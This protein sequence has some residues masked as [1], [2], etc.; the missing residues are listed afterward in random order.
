M[1]LELVEHRQNEPTMFLPRHCCC[2]FNQGFPLLRQKPLTVKNNVWGILRLTVLLHNEIQYHA[3]LRTYRLDDNRLSELFLAALL[4]ADQSFRTEFLGILQTGNPG[5]QT[6]SAEPMATFKHGVTNIIL[7]DQA[8]TTWFHII[9][10][11]LYYFSEHRSQKNLAVRKQS[12]RLV[13]NHWQKTPR[14]VWWNNFRS[15][16]TRR[17]FSNPSAKKCQKPES[18]RADCVTALLSTSS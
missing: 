5:F 15:P 8:L 16:K 18:G 13:F 4:H 3:E 11:I 14:W 7:T 1:F 17:S 2:L 10:S 6:R 12:N 9:C